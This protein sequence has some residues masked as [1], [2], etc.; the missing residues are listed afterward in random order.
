M[1]WLRKRFG[2]SSTYT[3]LALISAV[4]ASLAGPEA[5]AA[6]SPAAALLIGLWDFFRGEKKE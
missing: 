2:E 1:G 5:V 6:A 3:G 4:L